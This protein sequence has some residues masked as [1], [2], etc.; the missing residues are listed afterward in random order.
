MNKITCKGLE[1][2]C[3]NHITEGWGTGTIFLR[4]LGPHNAV[5]G[6][7]ADLMSSDMRRAGSSSTE[8]GGSTVYL[9]KNLKYITISKTVSN[10][11]EMVFLHPKATA[12]LDQESKTFYVLT[13]GDEIP[14][15]FFPRLDA[16]LNL[17][18]LP[19]WTPWLWKI[20]LEGA[21]TGRYGKTVYKQEAIQKVAPTVGDVVAYKIFAGQNNLWYK[22]ILAGLGIKICSRCGITCGHEEMDAIEDVNRILCRTCWES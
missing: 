21:E 5:K 3:L 6:I 14:N 7:W 11:L 16:L 13:Q 9:E 19:E 15:L 2:V 22:V 1:A 18:L 8:I 12:R 17:P 20:G 10:L 4:M